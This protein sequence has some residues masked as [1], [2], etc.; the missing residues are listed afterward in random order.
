MVGMSDYLSCMTATNTEITFNVFDNSTMTRVEDRVNLE[1][2]KD[3]LWAI[4]TK[5]GDFRS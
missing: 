1:D 2:G 4:P 5:Y 3:E